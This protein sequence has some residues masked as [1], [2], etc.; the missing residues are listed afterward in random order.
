ML[1][2]SRMESNRQMM[3]AALSA[4]RERRVHMVIGARRVL[5]LAAV[6]GI[7]ED[8]RFNIFVLV[9]SEADPFPVTPEARALWNAN[10][11]AAADAHYAIAVAGY[12]PDVMEA[13]DELLKDY[14]F[15][16]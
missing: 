11:L 7:Y 15:T 8:P 1:G 6:E 14:G 12:E 3:I 13:C 10:A 9:D 2:V 16:G 4:I 5:A